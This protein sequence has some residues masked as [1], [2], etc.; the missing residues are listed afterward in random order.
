MSSKVASYFCSTIGRK[1]LVALSGLVW[2]LFI[3]GHMAGN[4]LI[5]LG[6]EAYNRYGN[7]IATNPLLL[8]GTEVVLVL[9]LVTHVVLTVWLTRE[10]RK[11]RAQCYAMSTN[12]KK[13]ARPASKTMI[14]HGTIILVFII[15]HL[16]TFKYGPHYTVNY[17]GVEMRD[18]ARLMSEVFG[19]PMYVAWYVVSLILLFA[20]LSHGVASVFQTWG[21]NHPQYNEKINR[22]GYAYAFVVT[23]GFLSQPIYVFLQR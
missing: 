2:V 6:P 22:F 23:L 8:Y 7:A 15:T 4:M 12:G 1:Q 18:L 5:F 19:D 21:I 17:G 10:N 16:T 9:A 20:H 3:M 11:A 14:F 13:A